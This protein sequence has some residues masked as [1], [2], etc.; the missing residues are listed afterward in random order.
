MVNFRIDH[1]IEALVMLFG[2]FSKLKVHEVYTKES[3]QTFLALE[4][5]G[6]L[7]FFC[8]YKVIFILMYGEQRSVKILS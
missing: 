5:L 2:L 4:L 8:T 7:I 3:R 1:N 6:G